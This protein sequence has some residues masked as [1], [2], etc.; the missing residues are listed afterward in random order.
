ML[1]CVAKL[2]W[3]GASGGEWK[4]VGAMKERKSGPLIAVGAEMEGE[5][6]AMP[7]GGGKRSRTVKCVKTANRYQVQR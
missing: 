2:H 6:E 7:R 3:C 4:E 5:A 1:T